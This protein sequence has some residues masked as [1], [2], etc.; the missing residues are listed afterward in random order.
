MRTNS[1]IE[2][3]KEIAATGVCNNLCEHCPLYSM[4]MAMPNIPKSRV[5]MS[6]LGWC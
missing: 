2:I 3:V 4:C 1:M 6:W 5:A